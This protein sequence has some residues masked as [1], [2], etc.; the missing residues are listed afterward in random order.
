MKKYFLV[1]ITLIASLLIMGAFTIN[2]TQAINKEATTL[3][4]IGSGVVKVQPDFA[5][6]SL[7]VETKAKE[8][9]DAQSENAEIVQ[10]LIKV[11]GEQNISEQDII[12]SWFNI[13]P[14]YDYSNYG[15]KFS[16][17]RVSNQISVKVRDVV[18][19]GK[20]IDLATMTGAN[21][22]SGVQ[23]GVEENSRAYDESLKKAVFNAKQKAEVL[24]LTIGLDELRVV[25]VK[26]ISINYYNFE[27]HGFAMC[28]DNAGHTSI[29]HNSIDVSATV[30]VVFAA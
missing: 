9:E 11:F 27:R 28:S 16:G 12:T 4:V 8:I 20:I 25:S 7:S 21:N 24:S 29:M 2:S 6:I 1:V 17:Y 3:T 10:K 23:F 18:N 14:E 5:I 13:Y 22:I 26:E 15:Q 30:E 19:A